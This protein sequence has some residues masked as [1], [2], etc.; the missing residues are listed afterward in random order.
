MTIYYGLLPFIEIYYNRLAGLYLL[1]SSRAR[2]LLLFHCPNF[3]NLIL[4][5]SFAVIGCLI[6]LGEDAEA[7]I[8]FPNIIREH[9][10]SHSSL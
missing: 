6:F 8:A 1:K 5:A 4:R 9:S 3:T 7:Q 10:L 2:F